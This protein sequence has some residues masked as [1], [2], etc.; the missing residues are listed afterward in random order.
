MKHFLRYTVYTQILFFIF[1][2]VQVFSADE[3]NVQ[4]KK[5][6]IGINEKLGETIPLDASFLDEYGKPVTLRSLVTKPTILMLVY[7][8]CPGVCSPIMN[9]IASVVDK[10][11]M[12]AGKDY[13]LITIS[14]DP[15]EQYTTASEKKGNYLD[16]MKK[17]IPGESW[18]F[19]T[20]DS[21][22]I[23]LIT[24]GIGFGY[25]K[26]DGD[27]I[28]SSVVTIL[29][30][31]GKIAR[32]L[33]G[34]D[35]L[36]LEV[37]LALTEAAEGKTGPT[38]NKLLKLCFSYDPAGRKYVLNFTRIAGGIMILLIAGFVFAL[39][40]KKK[41]HNIPA[42]DRVSGVGKGSI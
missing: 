30:P 7:Y 9:S 22:N 4:E 40:F 6:E 3:P 42:N 26:K 16:V 34:T 28:H 41:K 32:Y 25:Q 10:L 18:K 8:R 21:V 2:S 15:S 35:F 36:P 17:K 33:Y 37:K 20:G 1:F 24:N 38:I 12:E 23:A 27:Y 11:D 19:L 13:N 5:V 14:F 39:T 31:N 29:S